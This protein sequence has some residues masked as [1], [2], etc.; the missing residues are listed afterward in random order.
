VPEGPYVAEYK[1][2]APPEGPNEVPVR[3]TVSPPPVPSVAAVMPEIT[4][5]VYASA[6]SKE[7]LCSPTSAEPT[8]IE[9]VN[10]VPTP[11]TVVHSTAVLSLVTEQPVAVYSVSSGL[12]VYVT[13]GCGVFA[14]SPTGPRLVPAIVIVSAPLVSRVPPEN[15]TPEITGAVYES[16][17]LEALLVWPLTVIFQASDVPRPGWLEHV[18]RV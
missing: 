14:V 2:S 9:N 7:S 8:V 18:I 5:A 10:A 3:V 13:T 15:V 17:A 12:V 16:V 6:D 1:A 4:G 11:A